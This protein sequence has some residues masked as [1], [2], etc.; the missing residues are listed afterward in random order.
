MPAVDITISLVARRRSVEADHVGVHAGDEAAPAVQRRHGVERLR[1]QMPARAATGT[2]RR[3]GHRLPQARALDQIGDDDRRC[4]RPRRSRAPAAGSDATTCSVRASSRNRARTA[5]QCGCSS[6]FRTRIA[7]GM[8]SAR[9]VPRRPGC[10]AGRGRACCAELVSRQQPGS[11][12]RR[13]RSG[14]R[15]PTARPSASTN[16]SST[17]SA[18][19]A[20]SPAPACTARRPPAAESAARVGGLDRPRRSATCLSSVARSAASNGRR[21]VSIS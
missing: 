15:P 19:P 2:A 4:A 11:R 3:L 16:S 13:P 9:C 14:A 20:P 10:P 5:S 6:R 1:H 21:P 7:T 18:R 12:P 17:A 8:P